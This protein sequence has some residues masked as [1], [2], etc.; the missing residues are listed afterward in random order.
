MVKSK[1]K[2]YKM[3]GEDWIFTI[4]NYVLCFLA[5]CITVYPLIYVFSM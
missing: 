3:T 5:A 1:R 2:R 4:V